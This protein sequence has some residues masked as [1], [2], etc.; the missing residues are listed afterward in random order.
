MN[1]S[2]TTSEALIAAQTV[3]S[4]EMDPSASTSEATSVSSSLEPAADLEK[5]EPVAKSDALVGAESPEDTA[6]NKDQISPAITEPL[7][8]KTWKAWG[9]VFACFSCHVFGIGWPA[10]WGIYQKT[11]LVDQDFP[12]SSN[13]NLSY[14]G[15]IIF[16]VMVVTGIFVGALADRLPISGLSLAGSVTMSA[17]LVASSFATELWHLYCS[18]ALF[19]LGASCSMVPATAVTPTW[20][21]K[22]RSLAMGI[23]VS[24]TGIGAF[25]I[26][27]ISQACISAGG[28]RL[29]M[30]VI[31][32]I[33]LVWMIIASL[34][35]RRK[36]PAAPR[37]GPLLTLV[38]FK[39]ETFTLVFLSVLVLMFNFFTP[40]LFV[41]LMM[42]YGGYPAAT[43]AAV[44]S[45][46]SAVIAVGRIVGGFFAGE[47]L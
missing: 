29:A 25:L 42:Y 27:A 23:A 7:P 19:G 47:L 16:A 13:F 6:D 5:A 20:F 28:W 45:A 39:N 26:S 32:G 9:V 18:Q 31:A 36:I 40:Q 17:S 15:T 46:F 1:A 41:P 44:V 37:K 38:F 33:M 30:R 21:I 24:G 10:S 43:G 22:H 3:P 12:G 34:L 4:T 8:D 11:L 35:L 2:M 14:A